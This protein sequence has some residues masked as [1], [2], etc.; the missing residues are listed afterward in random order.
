MLKENG[1]QSKTNDNMRS[2]TGKYNTEI[3]VE[4]RNLI[5]NITR[6]R[7]TS[8]KD[9]TR[10]DTKDMPMKELIYIFSEFIVLPLMFEALEK[11]N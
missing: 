7:K 2:M 8:T 9:T 1:E 6:T 5:W 4:D 10:H 11:F 3:S